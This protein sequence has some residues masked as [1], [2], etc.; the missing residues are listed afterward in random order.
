MRWRRVAGMG[1]L[2]AF[3]ACRAGCQG[4]PTPAFIRCPNDDGCTVSNGTGVY[5]VEDGFAGIGPTKLMITHFLNTGTQVG[6]SGR[7]FDPRVNLWF[8]LLAPG[9]VYSAEYQG[10][11]N[12]QVV[13]VTETNTVPTWT[14]TDPAAANPADRTKVVKDNDLLGLKLYIRFTIPVRDPGQKPPG[15]PNDPRAAAAATNGTTLAYQLDFTNRAVDKPFKQEVHAYQMRWRELTGTPPEEY[16][17]NQAH[18]PDPV[19]FQQGVDIDPVTGS[20]AR[21]AST[22]GFV[23]LSC[24]GGAPAIVYSWSYPYQGANAF[25]FDAGLHMKRASY[26]GDYNY[27]TKSPTSI[28]IADDQG[29]NSDPIGRLEARWSTTG[30]VC[31]NRSNVRHWS[32]ISAK[33]FTFSCNG[34]ALPTCSGS[35]TAP[36]LADGPMTPGP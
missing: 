13:S 34:H 10:K 2:V 8:P 30:A 27:Y 35:P 5:Y 4:P 31:V 15:T 12:L 9:L 23:T 3:S 14:L 33:G 18:A 19:V 36:F 7:Y 26:C 21:N 32:I 25:Y 22:A 11:V 6:F 28:Q 1:L 29:L 20:V 24:R 16:C 17:V